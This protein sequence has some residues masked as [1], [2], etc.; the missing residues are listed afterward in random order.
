VYLCVYMCLYKNK[1][2]CMCVCM[3]IYVCACVCISWCTLQLGWCALQFVSMPGT[4]I[5]ITL[6]YIY[7]C[8][9]AYWRA[10]HV[11]VYVC[12]SVFVCVSACPYESYKI[13]KG[14][15]RLNAFSKLVH[16]QYKSF[17]GDRF[18]QVE[19]KNPTILSNKTSNA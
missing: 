19:M 14:R 18:C 8:V 17:P 16:H 1:Y 13:F 12:M 11:R 2:M 9:N 3:C 15:P 4:H 6:S 10:V 7:V 5:H